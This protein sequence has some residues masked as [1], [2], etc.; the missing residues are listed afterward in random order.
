MLTINLFH[1]GCKIAYYR[2]LRGLTQKDLANKV[3][4]SPTTIGQIEQG[5]YNSDISLSMLDTIAKG[6]RVSTYMLLVDDLS[7]PILA[8]VTNLDTQLG[9][10]VSDNK[11]LVNKK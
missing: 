2:K 3:H 11:P 10:V 9:V 7:I 4:V 1:I 8:M 5:R 6:L